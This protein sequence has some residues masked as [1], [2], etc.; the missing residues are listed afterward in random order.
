M[1]EKYKK[2]ISEIIDLVNKLSNK[3]GNMFS[4]MDHDGLE[5]DDPV[6]DLVD[7][8]KDGFDDVEAAVKIIMNKEEK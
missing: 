7:D 8:I 6:F 5:F 1:E 2:Y 3:I 4:E